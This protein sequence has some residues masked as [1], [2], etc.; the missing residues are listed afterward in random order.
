MTQDYTG[1]SEGTTIAGYFE[2]Q[3][4]AQ[5]ALEELRDAGFSSAHMGVAHRGGSSTSKFASASGT[6]ATSKES[7]SNHEGMW[8]KMKDFFEG[9]SAEPYADE[10]AKGDLATREVTDDPYAAGDDYRYDHSDVHESLNSMSI[11]E[12]RSKYFGHRFGTSENGAVVTVKAGD[13]AAEAEEILRRNGGDLGENA[14]SYAY[15]ESGP[16][17]TAQVNDTQ[18]I[19]LLGEVLRVHKERVGLGDVRVRK[20]VI[21]ESQTVQVPVTREELVIERRAANGET[22]ARG[23]VGDGNEIRIPL[24]EER[25]SIDKST[26]VREEVTVGKRAVNEVRDVSGEVRRE[27]LVV[28]DEREP[29]ARR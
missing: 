6:G 22:E 16:A 17:A 5:R 4:A 9:R 15:P 10:K 24:S 7:K 19:Q 27:E 12:E 23:S 26:V 11:P 13:R 18:N 29:A 21:T 2:D 28:D 25:A 1:T 20:E 3:T 8:D 14:G